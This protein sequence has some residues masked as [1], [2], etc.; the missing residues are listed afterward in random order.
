[1]SINWLRDSLDEEDAKK[2]LHQ[3]TKKMQLESCI[4][5]LT[6]LAAKEKSDIL[7]NALEFYRTNKYLTPKF[8]FVVFWRLRQNNI[9]HRPSFFKISLRK[10]KYKYDLRQMETS[11]VHMFWKA[12]S[13]PQKQMALDMGHSAP[14]D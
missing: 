10:D 7:K 1:M 5:A 14:K 12:L 13:A 4:K 9:D 2:K 3:L 6:N 8:A 11:K